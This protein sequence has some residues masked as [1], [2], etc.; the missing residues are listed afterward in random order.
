MHLNDIVV[1]VIAERRLPRVAA[2]SCSTVAKEK[3]VVAR[4][5]AL[6]PTRNGCY[7]DGVGS[8]HSGV[9]LAGNG[10][11]GTGDDEEGGDREEGS[12]GMHLF[13]CVLVVCY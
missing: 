12:R 6:P 10:A 9:G 2:T 1:F 11:G 5:G 8:A 4:H 7:P 13:G 3:Q